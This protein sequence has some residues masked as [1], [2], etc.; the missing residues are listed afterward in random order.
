MKNIKHN[1]AK[2]VI[3]W[4]DH[5]YQDDDYTLEEINEKIK[6]PI[7]GEYIGYCIAESKQILCLASNIWED[8][9]ISQPMY[10]MKKCIIRRE[11]YE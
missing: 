8:G 11:I 4:A 10:I 9:T 2:M 1:Y 7:Y 5:F 3:T 6:S